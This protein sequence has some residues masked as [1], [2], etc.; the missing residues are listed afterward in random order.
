[1]STK[2]I[3]PGS[4]LEHDQLKDVGSNKELW[5]LLISTFLLRIGFAASLI[6]FD[7]QLVWG[8]ENTLGSDAVSEFGPIFLTA[9]AS[10]TF[11]IAEIFLTGYYGHRSDRT[12][13][14]P[15][16]LFATFGAAFVLLLYA[17]STVILVRAD[18]ALNSAYLSLVIMVLYLAA[19]HFVHGIV[20]SAKV[21]PTLGYIN[22]YST[23]NN[24][25]LRM[26]YYDN[27]VLYGRAVGMPFGG[28]LW[29]IM[30][31]EETDISVE[32]EARRI[33]WTFPIL[34]VVLLVATLFIIFGIKNTP[35]E[36]EVAPFSIKEDIS[37]AAKV[38]FDEKRK[39]LLVPW[40]A[41]AALIGAVSLWGPSIAFRTEGG[42]EER[43][44]SALIP[45]VI[46]VVALALPAPIWGKYADTHDRRSAL[47]I[48]IAGLPVILIGALVGYPFY[49]DDLSLTNIP[50]LISI[51]PGIMLLSALVPVMMGALGDTA[52]HGGHEDGQV[53][54]GYHFIIAAGEIIGIL[55]GGLFIGIFAMIQSMT[56]WFGE[57]S[58][59]EGEIGAGDSNALL[60]GFMLF[61]L[62]L[63]SLVVR[64]VLKIPHKE[65]TED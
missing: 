59:V 2:E 28:F 20:A 42:D 47:N 36:K 14:K 56:G 17:P 27:A 31:V 6:L 4:V 11:L 41:L 43:A 51:V 16:I 60:I 38:M 35:E 37:L 64:G 15:I 24:R 44:I 25:S 40:L 21:S 26:A 61:I 53:M 19:I 63:I 33:A 32:E 55:I 30:G 1:V 5:A 7:W 48:G 29:W 9:F 45:V 18:K 57:K 46:I 65:L 50:L 12:G 13:V 54:S 39:P 52:E 8:I 34:S 23:D 10:I 3:S 49:K 58:D 62:I 22:H